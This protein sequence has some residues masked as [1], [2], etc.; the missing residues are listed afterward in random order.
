MNSNSRH[1]HALNLIHQ[2]PVD[3]LNQDDM[4]LLENGGI[5]PSD[6]DDQS[7]V[8]H[9]YHPRTANIVNDHHK[10]NDTTKFLYTIS[11]LEQKNEFLQSELRR[12]QAAHEADKMR[13]AS[14]YRIENEKLISEIKHL[15]IKLSEADN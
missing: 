10:I 6:S 9:P 1:Q 13:M 7:T 8:N 15:R 14:S 11:S 2:L 4:Q 12:L 3:T 5:L